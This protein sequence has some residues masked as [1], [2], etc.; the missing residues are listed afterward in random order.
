MLSFLRK[1]SKNIYT[2]LSYLI[3]ENLIT[4]TQTC[5]IVLHY[6]NLSLIVPYG[7]FITP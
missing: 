1:F 7:L 2:L 6:S 3:G 5:V 4:L